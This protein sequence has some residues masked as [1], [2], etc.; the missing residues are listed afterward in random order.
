MNTVDV[1]KDLERI[2][3]R[4]DKK[5]AKCGALSDADIDNMISGARRKR[6]Q[7]AP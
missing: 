6:R 3:A 2:Y 4:I 7:R 5:V 1:V